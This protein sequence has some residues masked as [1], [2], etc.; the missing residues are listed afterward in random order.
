MMTMLRHVPREPKYLLVLI[1][2][3]LTVAGIGQVLFIFSS[4]EGIF[5]WLCLL[6]LVVIAT[7]LAGQMARGMWT[8]YIAFAVIVSVF[9]V[10]LPVTLFNVLLGTLLV[11]ARQLNE[12]DGTQLFARRLRD[13]LARIMLA[14]NGAV[15]LFVLYY[16]LGGHLPLTGFSD[17]RDFVA[18]SVA[19]LVLYAF[20]YSA[21][22]WLAGKTREETLAI[23]ARSVAMDALLC[24]VAV[25]AP[26]IRQND[27]SGVMV[28]LLVMVMVQAVRYRQ[29]SDARAELEQRAREVVT[30]SNLGQAVSTTLN[31]SGLLARVHQQ[32]AQLAGGGTIFTA[33]YDPKQQAIDYPLVTSGDEV[34]HWQRR[35]LQGGLTDWVIRNREPLLLN[36]IDPSQFEAMGIHA[37]D[38]E[39]RAYMGVP[40]MVGDELIGVLGILH[41]ENSEAFSHVGL[42]VLKAI[43]SQASLAIRNANLYE[44]TARLVDNLALINHSLQ[45]VMFNLDRESA[46]MVACEVSCSVTRAHKAAVFMVT[47]RVRLRAVATYHTRLPEDYTLVYQS[48]LYVQGARHVPN[49]QECDDEQLRQLA[50]ELGFMATLE[51]PLRTGNTVVGLLA[52]YHEHPHYYDQSDFNL[53]EMVTSQVTAAFD[54]ADLLQA[55]E[56][57]AGEQAQLVQLSRMTSSHL[58]LERV[59]VEVCEVLKQMLDVQTVDVCFVTEQ[60]GILELHRPQEGR[61]QQRQLDLSACPEMTVVLQSPILSNPYILYSDDDSLSEAMR[62]FMLSEGWQTLAITT[63]LVNKRAFGVLFL[64]SRQK[65]VFLDSHRRL[66]EMATNQ[67][68]AQ[69]YNARLHLMTERALAQQL[70]QLALIEDIARKVSQSLE[71]NVI[72]SNV[73][74]AARQSTQAD[75]VEMALR[76]ETRWQIITPAKTEF[77]DLVTVFQD[78]LSSA[79]EKVV[80]TGIWANDD[81]NGSGL[82]VP[83][84]S[85][86]D[87]LGVLRVGS[88]KPNAF[89]QEHVRFIQSL[90]GHA[91]ISIGNAELLEE[92]QAQINTLTA[93]R[94]LTLESVGIDN[95]E[96][97]ALAILKATLKLLGGLESALYGYD[98]RTDELVIIASATLDGEDLKWVIPSFSPALILDA[99]HEGKVCLTER[100]HAP[101]PTQ[102]DERTPFFSTLAIPIWRNGAIREVIA[103]GY[104]RSV[105]FTERDMNTVALLSAQVAGHLDNVALNQALRASNERS[106][107]ILD[108]TRDGIIL[109][110][111]VGRV[112]DANLA[113]SSVLQIDLNKHIGENFRRLLAN[114]YPDEGAPEKPSSSV[115][116]PYGSILELGTFGSGESLP[117]Q[118]EFRLSYRDAVDY[119]QAQILP[120]RDGDGVLV[121]RLLLLR[122][123]TEEKNLANTRESL[124]RMVIHDLRSPLGAII[125]SLA[126]MQILVDD[127]PDDQTSDIRKTISISLESANTLMRL[128]DTLRDLPRM[129]DRE[130]RLEPQMLSL[131]QLA[132]KAYDMLGASFKEANI[133]M[134]IRVPQDLQVCVDPDLT[135]R[136]L[137][138]LLHNAFKFTPENGT[139][140]IVAEP[141]KKPNGMAKVLVCDTGPGIPADKRDIIFEEFKQVDNV[142][143]VRGGRGT[144]LGLT[145]C[146][147][148]VEAHGGAIRLEDEGLLPGACFSLTLPT[149]PST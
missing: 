123:I 32:I 76:T 126:F 137:I 30:L 101:D 34:L 85:G 51:V 120:V 24:I 46:M 63:M 97:V 89:T 71:L 88:S 87:V 20:L 47:D 72:I 16:G 11:W 15:I 8:G 147:L 145:F 14:G 81:V 131:R 39:S 35:K 22:G 56:L 128:M 5:V 136:V 19:C 54:N 26:I 94:T 95:Q 70:E 102:T 75:E 117:A 41:R 1:P 118:R 141:P 108:S 99:V 77:S 90:A 80:Q 17:L 138:N 113:A 25:I 28:V 144:G 10:G 55:L 2:C 38:V 79:M 130:M 103:V 48:D 53:L 142:S 84:F 115:P 146:R 112:Q 61:I 111:N 66:L 60:E 125:S 105:R 57:Y 149:T 31:L 18:L 52:V 109:L 6:S 148:A 110:D 49:V 140:L 33:L 58:D 93:L 86:E 73:L 9:V 98:A 78:R 42:S 4:A 133:N 12:Q 96:F 124:Q 143:P 45:D 3:V 127:F 44:R 37:L 67:V 91:A 50:I 104:A 65:T 129:K 100:R 68:S 121:G 122:D 64:G 13:A 135:R 92:R 107:V 29:I 114:Y 21:G 62:D 83:L 82:I 134:E 43:A 7:H 116:S 40:L 74:D 119:V 69:I 23:A 59:I 27:G 139:I 132:Q 106:R 36:T